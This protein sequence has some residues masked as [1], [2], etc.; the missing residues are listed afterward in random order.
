MLTPEVMSQYAPIFAACDSVYGDKDRSATLAS[1]KDWI[2]K[3]S[4][5]E[6]ADE[7]ILAAV[8]KILGVCITTV[9]HTPLGDD[10]WAIA[11]H[12]LEEQ[13]AAASITDEIVMGN[14]DVHYVWL[15]G[16]PVQN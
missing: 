8:A 12:P 14:D 5:I 10:M 16:V 6:F 7:L 11:Q 9:P 3:V 1:Y 2:N 15:H 4:R 13:W